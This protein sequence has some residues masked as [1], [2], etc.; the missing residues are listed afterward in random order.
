MQASVPVRTHRHAH[1]LIICIY[2]INILF[3]SLTHSLCIASGASYQRLV[4]FFSF[5]KHASKVIFTCLHIAVSVAMMFFVFSMRQS[6]KDSQQHAV[7]IRPLWQMWFAFGKGIL[8]LL[9]ET[10]CFLRW[11][12]QCQKWHYRLSHWLRFLWSYHLRSIPITNS[13]TWFYSIIAV[14]IRW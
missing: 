5:Y 8:W 4:W 11:W 1:M 10:F 13:M 14:M 2:Q 6:Y 9:L 7:I 12:N 3:V